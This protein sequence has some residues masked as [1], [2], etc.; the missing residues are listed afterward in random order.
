LAL[1]DAKELQLDSSLDNYVETVKKT[2]AINGTDANTTYEGN[3]YLD[4]LK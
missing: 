1:D 2:N 4:F 3:K